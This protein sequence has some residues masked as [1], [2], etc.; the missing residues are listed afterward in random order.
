MHTQTKAKTLSLIF[1]FWQQAI[2][3]NNSTGSKLS[4]H[5]NAINQ[6][7]NLNIWINQLKKGVFVCAVTYFKLSPAHVA[8]MQSRLS[9]IL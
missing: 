9:S 3:M 6:Q 2:N 5:H 8:L 1:V 4:D 7:N